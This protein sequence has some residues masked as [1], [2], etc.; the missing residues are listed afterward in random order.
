[1]EFVTSNQIQ[2]DKFEYDKI[3]NYVI[4]LK[5]IGGENQ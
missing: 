3:E 1:M 2:A 5:T 4:M